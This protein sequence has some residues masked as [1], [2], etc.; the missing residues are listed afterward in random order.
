MSVKINR[1]GIITIKLTATMA[2]ALSLLCADSLIDEGE[3]VN[4]RALYKALPS[5]ASLTTNGERYIH[6]NPILKLSADLLPTFTLMCERGK[7]GG[8]T[9]GGAFQRRIDGVANLPALQLLAT[10]G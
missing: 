6:G 7:W 1:K 4:V 9:Q 10:A 3:D 8:W 5:R 2:F